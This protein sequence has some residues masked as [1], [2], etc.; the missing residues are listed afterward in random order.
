MPDARALTRRALTLGVL[1]AAGAA[2]AAAVRGT[3]RPVGDDR[4]VVD[5]GADDVP[6]GSL[7]RP[8]PGLAVPGRDRAHGVLRGAVA[9]RGGRC[10]AAPRRPDDL[11]PAP[12]RRLRRAARGT[13]ARQAGIGDLDARTAE[14]EK[15]AARYAGAGAARREPLPA[16]ELIAVV[17]QARPGPGRRPTGSGSRPRSSPSTSPP[18]GAGGRCCC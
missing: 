4:A 15:V 5:V 1:A 3:G 17:A 6:A 10:R 16:L 8:D 9:V 14:L 11:P 2:A 13:R 7:R 12:C 18:P